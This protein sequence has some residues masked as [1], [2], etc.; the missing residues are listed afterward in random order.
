MYQHS[1]NSN[2]VMEETRQWRRGRGRG[3]H[4][5]PQRG[6]PILRNV[7][8]T[9]RLTTDTRTI[10]L[11]SPLPMVLRQCTHLRLHMGQKAPL[12]RTI[13]VPPHPRPALPSHPAE[14][15][16]PLIALPCIDMTPTADRLQW[17]HTT[18]HPHPLPTIT[19][20]LPCM[21]PL[22][23]TRRSR[24]R[25]V[26]RVAKRPSRRTGSRSR[27]RGCSRREVSAVMRQRRLENTTTTTTTTMTT[28]RRP[29]TNKWTRGWGWMT[30][31]HR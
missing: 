30:V 24:L 11:R 29:V 22:L 9:F 25:R 27:S 26:E 15:P 14:V 1:S 5:P 18:L 28:D 2:R 17:I 6:P 3:R 13:T 23:Q 4:L 31:I 12:Q 19:L 20:T 16:L 7:T 21:R 10:R 8:I